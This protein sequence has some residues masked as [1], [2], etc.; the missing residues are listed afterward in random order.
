MT[1]SPLL[2]AKSQSA[3]LLA[4]TPRA[5]APEAAAATSFKSGGKQPAAA[6]PPRAPKPP[7]NHQQ[8]PTR[9][10][11]PMLPGATPRRLCCACGEFYMDFAQ[12][13]LGKWN[14]SP[15]TCC[16]ACH[17]RNKP[18]RPR[19]PKHNSNNT[20]PDPPPFVAPVVAAAKGSFS[21]HPRLDIRI[22]MPSASGPFDVVVPGAVVDSGTQVCLLPEQ[23]LRGFP[24]PTN[25]CDPSKT[26]VC[27]ANA[28]TIT[29]KGLVE[30]TISAMSNTNERLYHNGKI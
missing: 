30:G 17:L 26:S 22:S 3:T 5:P 9:N 24:S 27:M 18:P 8:D 21:G 13:Q 28:D 16:K 25:C 1:S 12:Y 23:A 29:I 19:Y 7:K 11:G 20:D 6:A 4:P 2:K 15:H 14:T 10:S